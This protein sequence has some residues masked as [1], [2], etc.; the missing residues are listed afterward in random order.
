MATT[1]HPSPVLVTG[2]A[3]A[4]AAAVR[5]ARTTDERLRTALWAGAAALL[6][7]TAAIAAAATV[8][9]NVVLPIHI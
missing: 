3:P 5:E 6:G 2:T 1:L 8:V 9:H 4:R 7:A